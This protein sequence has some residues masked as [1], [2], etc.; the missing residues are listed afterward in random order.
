M[1]VLQG[2]FELADVAWDAETMTLSGTA[3][4]PGGESGS[5]FV[6]VP[7][8]LHVVNPHG[9]WIGKDDNDNTLVIRR[10]FAFGDEPEGWEI[11]FAPITTGDRSEYGMR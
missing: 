11:Q 2:N 8:G 1:H 4:R 5:L 10:A 7:E 9:L 3:S 6:A